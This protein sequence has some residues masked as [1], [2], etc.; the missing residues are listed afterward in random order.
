M[1]RTLNEYCGLTFTNPN[2][3]R[4]VVYPNNTIAARLLN[5]HGASVSVADCVAEDR[6]NLPMPETLLPELDRK[7]Q[8][9]GGRVVVV[10]I[11]AYLSL[12]SDEKVT[13]FFTALRRRIDAGELNAVYLVS[14]KHNLRFGKPGYETNLDVIKIS[15]DFE[16]VEPP[17]VEVVSDKW[18]QPNDIKDYNA[19]LKQLGDF[20]PTEECKLVLKDIK[21]SQAGLGNNVSFVCDVRQ[22]AERFYGISADLSPTTIE[23]WLTKAKESGKAPKSYLEE[24]FGEINIDARFAIKR[25]IKLPD[26][27]LWP[28]YIWLLQ[29]RL[30]ADTYFAKVLSSDIT[31]GN[32]LRKY[33]VDT[34]ATLLNDNNAKKFAEERAE[35]LSGL[36]DKNSLIIDFIGQ[37]KEI[38]AA[39]EFLN[40]GT[41]AERIDIVRRASCF[42]LATG[43]PTVLKRLYPTLADYLSSEFNYGTNELNGYFREYRRLKITNTITAEFVKKAF[44]LV[45]STS[46]PLRDSVLLGL[47]TDDTALLVVDGM[48]AEYMPLL[49]AMA[50]R[51]N[52]NV[53]SFDVVAAKLP[54]ST[55]PFNPI[56]WDK[57]NMLN[58]IR[59]V[60]NI[61]H[62]GAAKHE[63]C[64]PERNI[65][66]VLSV[67]E[68]EV[69]NRI[70]EGL[71]KYPRVVVTADHGS[72]R[73]AVIAHDKGYSEDLPWD[74][75]RDGEPLDWR[76]SLAPENANRPPEFERQYHPDTEKTYWVVRG[77]NRLPKQ[78]GKLNELHG[79]A[80]LEERLVPVV[81]FTNAE[82]VVQS[83]KLNKEKE[84][85][86]IDKM[87]FDIL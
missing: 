51:R 28:A 34:A 22:I 55:T 33:V 32:L 60:D 53:E 69:F 73:L 86:I 39:S 47:R 19:L 76:Y 26:D 66:A 61:A 38:D 17:K 15:G 57:N 1:E 36:T 24:E 11:D 83:K 7:I 37:T 63:Y 84:E 65:A 8:E 58:E 56:L 81:V 23:L 67:F 29:K 43:L 14:N 48:G 4:I 72:S 85:Q 21:S 68:T 9:R 74:K 31:H 42:D 52:M 20:L 64:P 54:T 75:N 13:A 25:L 12:L 71:S 87:G 50:K 40:C 6:L 41:D 2:A 82:T 18:V 35:A 45:L 30:S 27:A 80:S 77:Y 44:D 79:G 16:Y 5:H 59:E 3:P 49:L 10:G 70:A 62:N 78:G 46:F